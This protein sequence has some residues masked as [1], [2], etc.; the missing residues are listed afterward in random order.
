[1]VKTFHVTCSN[2]TFSCRN[3]CRRIC[4]QIDSFWKISPSHA[5]VIDLSITDIFFKLIDHILVI[6]CSKMKSTLNLKYLLTKLWSG[7]YL[8]EYFI[9][10]H[11]IPRL[12]VELLY[13]TQIIDIFIFKSLGFINVIVMLT[14]SL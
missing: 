4:R 6:S 9:L 1:M 5:T 10:K 12:K 3:A 8:I 2:D 13:F 7:Y 14:Y 11:I